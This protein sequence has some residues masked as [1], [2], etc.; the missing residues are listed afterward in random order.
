MTHA[1]ISRGWD[2]DIW[3]ED[4]KQV[5]WT[6][7]F[8]Q[9]DGLELFTAGNRCRKL[10]WHYFGK[11]LADGRISLSKPSTQ[12]ERLRER[13]FFSRISLDEAVDQFQ[14]NP[15]PSS[16]R[17]V[18]DRMQAYQRDTVD[19]HAAEEKERRNAEGETTARTPIDGIG[20]YERIDG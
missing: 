13:V 5:R 2:V 17:L 4:G 6:V 1:T 11:L 8:V 14:Q 7:D 12:V 10:T 3:E 18:C 15:S 9:P 20:G 19:L 16:F